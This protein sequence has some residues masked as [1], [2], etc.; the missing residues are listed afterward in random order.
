MSDT[1]EDVVLP[2][3]ETDDPMKVLREVRQLLWADF[4]L[5]E[6]AKPGF[7]PEIMRTVDM[8]RAAL[9]DRDTWKRLAESAQ[10][11]AEVL[12]QYEED[13]RHPPR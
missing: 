13:E 5:D 1:T 12:R 11:R 9:Q 7:G 3:D 6:R 2:E 8:V 10:R 4:M